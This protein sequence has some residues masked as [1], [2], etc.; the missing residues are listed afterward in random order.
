MTVI[1]RNDASCRRLGLSSQNRETRIKKENRDYY[2]FAKGLKMVNVY[3]KGYALI[4]GKVAMNT[5]GLGLGCESMLQRHVGQIIYSIT[6]VG[7]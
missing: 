1:P 5:R 6:S 2:L 4:T 3:C 7:S